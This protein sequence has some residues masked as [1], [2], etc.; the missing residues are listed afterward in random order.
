MMQDAPDLETISKAVLHNCELMGEVPTLKHRPWFLL[1]KLKDQTQSLLLQ[2]IQDSNKTTALFAPMAAQQVLDMISANESRQQ[3][4]LYILQED[5]AAREAMTTIDEF[6]LASSLVQIRLAY[7]GEGA[8]LN[9]GIRV[10]ELNLFLS[11]GKEET[12]QVD[13]GDTVCLSVYQDNSLLGEEVLDLEPK[14]YSTEKLRDSASLPFTKDTSVAGVKVCLDITLSLNPQTKQHLLRSKISQLEEDLKQL[15][16]SESDYSE[17]LRAL[18]VEVVNR[19]AK[20]TL[21]KK[22][23][24]QPRKSEERKL[25]RD[26]DCCAAF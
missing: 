12:L 11:P 16:T 6:S 20:S 26:C 13:L 10:G 23:K 5:V 21:P 15:D 4:R 24:Q 22:P 25:E 19:E 18:D 14:T 3:I 9:A 8:N 2:L 17:L 7:I 1:K